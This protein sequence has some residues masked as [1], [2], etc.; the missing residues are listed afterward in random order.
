MLRHWESWLLRLAM[1][2]LL[3]YQAVSGNRSGATVAGEGCL[4]SL[5]PL[6]VTRWSR[7]HIPRPLE[8]AFVGGIALQF[9]SES[10][11]LFELFTYWDKIVHPTLIALTSMCGVWLMLGYRDAFEKR[12][13]IQFAALFALLLG[14]CVGACWEFFEF[15]SDWFGDANL[16]KSNADT[17]TDL[18]ANDLGAFVAMLFGLWVYER[19]LSPSQRDGMGRIAAWLT[20]GPSR[21]LDRHG[22]L[23]GTL[24]ALLFGVV[25]IASQWIDRG[26]PALASGLSPGQPA[27]WTFGR[28]AASAANTRVLSGDWVADERGICRENPE[29]PRPGSEKMGVLELAPGS[30]YGQD[31]QAFSVQARYYEERPPLTEGTEMDAG[32]A[33]GVRDQSNFDLLEQSALHDFIRVDRYVHGNRR[34]IRE[35]LLRTHADEWHVLKLDVA[36]ASVS[37][38]IDGRLI[39]TTTMAETDGG[40][41][42]WARAAAA[43]C[44][45]DAQIQ[46]LTPA[47]DQAAPW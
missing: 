28:D 41:G 3:V 31:G 34:D 2:A 15:G 19:H 4:I 45:S 11:K 25:L 42:L 20:D 5:L 46:L 17:L 1:L 40:V 10:T 38:S 44:F 32:I 27:S 30:V 23:V 47:A 22:R 7:V 13:P 21:L 33:F 18:L 6:L 29:H 8:F 16:Q 36:G 26:T 24:V 43:T 39:F 12:L 9:I 14:M 35:E 37:A